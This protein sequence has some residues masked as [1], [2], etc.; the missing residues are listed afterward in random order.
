MNTANTR[1]GVG[2]RPHVGACHLSFRAS[3][4]GKIWPPAKKP[5]ARF[6]YGVEFEVE[7]YLRYQGDKFSGRFDANTYLLMTRALDYFDP[8][9]DA[10]DDLTKA[11]SSVTAEFLL[12]SFSSDWRFPPAFSREMLRHLL[13]AGK[14]ASYV[15]VQSG[16][17]HD[18]FL[19]S[20]PVYHRAVGAFM[21]RLAEKLGKV[22][23]NCAL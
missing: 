11:L 22:R 18:S 13:A 12:V 4:G 9:Q 6:D 15:K 5:T 14:R 20:N 7:S 10:D 16:E 17:G 23:L 1:V 8:A 19:L 3:F 21:N 2:C